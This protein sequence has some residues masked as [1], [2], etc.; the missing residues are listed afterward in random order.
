MGLPVGLPEG[1]FSVLYGNRGGHHW[2]TRHAIYVKSVQEQRC[3]KSIE[4][5][6]KVAP[7]RGAGILFSDAPF[8][9]N[10]QG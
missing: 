8:P 7:H 3:L 9:F 4:K 6:E 1:V 5:S 2:A 10:V